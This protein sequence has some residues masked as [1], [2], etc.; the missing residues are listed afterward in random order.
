[1]QKVFQHTC[2]EKKSGKTQSTNQINIR[3][4][5]STFLHRL[6]FNHMIKL[7]KKNKK[8]THSTHVD[9]K[10]LRFCRVNISQITNDKICAKKKHKRFQ[11]WN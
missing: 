9:L 10:V 3:F 6:N 11:I 4:I 8:T 7:L 5:F 1:M 2:H